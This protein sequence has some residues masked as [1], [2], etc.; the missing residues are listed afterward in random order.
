[1]FQRYAAAV[2]GFG[3][4]AVSLSLGI[5]S[6]LLCLVSAGAFYTVAALAQRKRVDR[7]TAEFMEKSRDRAERRPRA[8]T[9]RSA[10]RSA[11]DYA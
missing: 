2:V 3:F 9:R 7:F 8:D 4:A 11:Y 1:M 6:A 5:G 10:S